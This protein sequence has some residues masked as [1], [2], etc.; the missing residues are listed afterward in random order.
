MYGMTNSGKLFADDLT[1][2]LIKEGFIQSKCQMYIY[3]KY[4][5]DGSKI[6]VYLSLMIVFIGTQMKIL[7][8]GL[9]IPWA[10]DSMLTS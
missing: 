3:Y 1:K 6:V 2:W 8:S 9:L 5:P 10:R 7:E 4:A